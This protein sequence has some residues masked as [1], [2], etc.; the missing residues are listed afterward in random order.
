MKHT[1]GPSLMELPQRRTDPRAAR[2]VRHDIRHCI[3]G[4]LKAAKTDLPRHTRQCGCEEQH[5]ES[6]TPMCEAGREVQQHARVAFHRAADVTE[7]HKRTR[8]RSPTT[9]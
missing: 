2:P 3:N 9:G 8:S 7:E 6:P 5:L 4:L 1:A